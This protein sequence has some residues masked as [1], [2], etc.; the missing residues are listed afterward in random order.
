[1]AREMIRFGVNLDR[2]VDGEFSEIAET[3]EHRPK[4]DLHRVLINRIVRLWK[5]QPEALEQLGLIRRGY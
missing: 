5:E 2:K 1:M 4:V 3:V